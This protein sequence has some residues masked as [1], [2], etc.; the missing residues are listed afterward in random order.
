MSLQV[1]PEESLVPRIGSSLHSRGRHVLLLS[2]WLSWRCR[3]CLKVSFPFPSR[4]RDS[5]PSGLGT[6]LHGCLGL[7][8][9]EILSRQV[10]D[11]SC[12]NQQGFLSH[13]G[14]V[15]AS[16]VGHRD[17]GSGLDAGRIHLSTV[18]LFPFELFEHREVSSVRIGRIGTVGRA[19]R[20][21]ATPWVAC[22]QEICSTSGLLLTICPVNVT[23][24]L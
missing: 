4:S 9:N 22:C 1:P 20:C 17:P 11:G 12:V 14:R 6:V 19:G 3:Q 10:V 18:R 8:L 23:T 2:G 15:L 21:P 7:P 24:A 5:V 16:Y 13:G